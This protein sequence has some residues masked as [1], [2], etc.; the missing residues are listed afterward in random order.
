VRNFSNLTQCKANKNWLNFE[1]VMVKYEF[2]F[3][4]HRPVWAA[5]VRT[6]Y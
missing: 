4:E 1:R 5:Y 6:G 3:I 2:I